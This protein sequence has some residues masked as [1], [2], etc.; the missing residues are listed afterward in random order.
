ME[1]HTSRTRT[2]LMKIAWTEKSVPS[3]WRR[4]VVVPVP[5]DQNSKTLNQ[6][7]SIALL[8]VE[9]KIFFSVMA[10]R[11]YLMDNSYYY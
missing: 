2:A 7:K 9:W 1:F 4:A 5:K 3:E 6:F 11:T 8:I 10:R